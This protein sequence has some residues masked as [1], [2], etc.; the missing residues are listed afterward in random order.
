MFEVKISFQIRSAIP[1]IPTLTQE[2]ARDATARDLY[3]WLIGKLEEMG[4]C[5]CCC[6]DNTVCL[7][8]CGQKEP[9]GLCC[10]PLEMFASSEKASA[11]TTAAKPLLSFFCVLMQ[12]DSSE[13]QRR[14]TS[15]HNILEY[16]Q[17]MRNYNE[18]DLDMSRREC[19]EYILSRQVQDTFPQTREFHLHKWQLVH[20]LLHHGEGGG[21]GQK[22]FWS[23]H[24][25][26]VREKDHKVNDQQH[27]SWCKSRRPLPIDVA[28]PFAFSTSTS[29]SLSFPFSSLT[30]KMKKNNYDFLLLE[31][32]VPTGLGKDLWQI[33][34][35]YYW[36]TSWNIEWILQLSREDDLRRPCQLVRRLCQETCLLVPEYGKFRHES[37]KFR[38][39]P[40][41]RL[42]LVLEYRYV[43]WLPRQTVTWMAGP[44]G[45]IF[46]F[47]CPQLL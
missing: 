11:I 2:F 38:F 41:N 26:H 34:L 47:I 1:A 31:S 5:C 10:E 22:S 28:L 18:H 27:R 4:C 33:V 13:S 14:D 17:R 29:F 21:E 39:Q 9:W 3:L 35:S 12:K 25:L 45:P 32:S 36:Q 42:S 15:L 37:L 43:P 30:E 23:G 19:S 16:S 8:P 46:S 20:S 6:N 7:R 24:S 44:Q 40:S